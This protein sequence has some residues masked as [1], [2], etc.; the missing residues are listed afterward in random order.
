MDGPGTGFFKSSLSVLICSDTELSHQ[1]S[2]VH[3]MPPKCLGRTPFYLN[4]WLL[5]ISISGLQRQAVK[6]WAIEF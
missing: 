5:K 6:P 4:N 1:S 2:L 3:T